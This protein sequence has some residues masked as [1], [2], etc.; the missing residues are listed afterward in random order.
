MFSTNM[1]VAD[2]IVCARRHRYKLCQKCPLYWGVA[3]EHFS[4][5]DQTQIRERSYGHYIR[6]TIIQDIIDMPTIPAKTCKNGY[7]YT[8]RNAREEDVFINKDGEREFFDK[9]KCTR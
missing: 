2:V 5:D 7:W 3:K 9:S 1:D 6:R 4:S 8:M